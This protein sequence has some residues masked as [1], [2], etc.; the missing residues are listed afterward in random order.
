MKKSTI[1]SCATFSLLVGSSP[2]LAQVA[3]LQYRSVP[4]RNVQEFVYR[5]T[6]FWSEVARKAIN[7]G[8]M[9]GW[10]LWQRVG[11]MNVDDSPNFFFVNMFETKDGIGQGGIWDPAAVFPDRR[12]SDMSTNGMSSTKHQLIIQ[13]D[14]YVG[15]EQAQYMVVNYAKASDLAR[16]VE[17]E[18][19]VWQPFITEQMNAKNT[20]QTSWGVATVLNPG[21]DDM[22]FNAMTVDG[23][24]TLSG[25]ISANWNPDVE[26]EFP[27]LT[28]LNDVHTKAWIQVYSLVKAVWAEQ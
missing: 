6:T 12:P 18:R 17:L 2:L 1:L 16:Y 7:E 5:E 26:V 21:G 11:G 28:E 25:A 24:Q 4:P 23:F 8:K 15:E 3:V 10:E 14:D 9:L 19:T 13:V 20:D 22:P 27:D